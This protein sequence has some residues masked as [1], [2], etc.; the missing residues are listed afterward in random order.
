MFTVITC[1]GYELCMLLKQSPPCKSLISSWPFW[2]KLSFLLLH[3]ERSYAL[4]SIEVVGD[5]LHMGS[6]HPM[7]KPDGLRSILRHI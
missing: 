1:T 6:L 5:G 4:W 2:G 3:H 7:L